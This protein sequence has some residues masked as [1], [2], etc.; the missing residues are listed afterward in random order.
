M[1]GTLS[2][3]D[4]HYI[5]G[6]LYVASGENLVSVTLGERI[7]DASAEEPRDVDIAVVT[8]GSIGLFAA[9][10]KDHARPLDVTA[11]EQLCQKLL[12][13][14]DILKRA[15]VSS[16]G[17]TA[18]SRRKAASHDVQCLQ[19]VRGALPA[20][21]PGIQISRLAEMTVVNRAWTEQPQV[22]IGPTTQLTPTE[23]AAIANCTPTRLSDGT[24]IQL[25][26]LADRIAQQFDPGAVEFN[27][28]N[29]VAVDEVRPLDHPVS[30]AVGDRVVHMQDARIVGRVQRTT[31]ILPLHT[32]CYLADESG[33]AFASAV[34]FEL[35][36]TLLA[37]TVGGDGNTLR[38]F[39]IPANVRAER[40]NR[41]RIFESTA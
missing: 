30:I 10:V 41:R 35:N 22:T 31:N 9:E 37:L 12:D 15:I 33:S 24:E 34:L 23:K 17:F 32:S 5:V 4:I 36:Q 39:Q 8:A 18:P 1:L 21:G 13:M 3:T 38:L 14:P 28:G 26:E 6:Y 29:E 27:G 19:L 11:V 2:D 16:S 7:Y 25:K 20:L 40:P